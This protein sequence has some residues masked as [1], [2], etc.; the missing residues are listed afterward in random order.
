MMTAL[1]DTA[2]SLL[3]SIDTERAHPEPE[4]SRGRRRRARRP[5]AD[6]RAV[7]LGR[8]HQPGGARRGAIERFH[9]LAPE[10]AADEY[11]NVFTNEQGEERVIAWRAAP[12]HGPDGTVE[13]IVAGGMDITERQRLA[14]EKERE[15]AFLNAIAN[16]APSLLCLIDETG[17][18]ARPRDEQGVRALARL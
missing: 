5:G 1:T 4:S 11:E 15:R 3:V 2:P 7:L 10:F 8:V 9:A 14:E 6:A 12:V 16:D 17:T 13:S 18:V